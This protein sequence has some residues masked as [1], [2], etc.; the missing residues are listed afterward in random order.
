MQ[1]VCLLAQGNIEL[2]D[3][4]VMFKCP[5]LGQHLCSAQ[6][7]PQLHQVLRALSSLTLPVCRGRT[8]TT[9]LGS[10]CQCLITFTVKDFPYIQSKS[11]LSLRNHFHFPHHN[12][13]CYRVCPLLS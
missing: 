7:H 11:T 10:L 8:S 9:P 12:K 2:L 6:G 4:E 3:L 13:H 1:L 5:F